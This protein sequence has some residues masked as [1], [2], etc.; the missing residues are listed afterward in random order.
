MF[1]FM[2]LGLL[3]FVVGAAYLLTVGY[4]LTPSHVTLRSERASTEQDVFL[5]EIVVGD[6]LPFRRGDA[7][8]S[9]RRG[10]L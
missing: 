4:W 3:V 8:E 9:A 2:H 1:E 7:G 5:T 6:E 10:G